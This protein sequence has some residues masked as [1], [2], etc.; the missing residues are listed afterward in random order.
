M[1]AFFILHHSVI[2]F[3]YCLTLMSAWS[4]CFAVG[5][6]RFHSLLSHTKDCTLMLVTA[7]LLG[8]QNVQNS[9]SSSVFIQCYPFSRDGQIHPIPSAIACTQSLHLSRFRASS[10]FKIIFS[11]SS[12]YFFQVFFG[13]PCFLLPLTSRSR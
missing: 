6:P 5:R 8:A 7:S 10:F 11:V 2:A 1:L 9:S 13:R 12:T 3:H 4:V